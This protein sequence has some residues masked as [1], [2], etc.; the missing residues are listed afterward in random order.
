MDNEGC[1]AILVFHVQ[2]WRVI[3]HELNSP[4]RLVD[5]LVMHLSDCMLTKEIKEIPTLLPR[6]EQIKMRLQ[7]LIGLTADVSTHWFG[8]LIE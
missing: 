3:I 2:V 1:D 7:I 5:F 8:R 6:S 4:C